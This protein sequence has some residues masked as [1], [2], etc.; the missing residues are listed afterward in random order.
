MIIRP[1]NMLY[2][3]PLFPIQNSVK[4]NIE[5]NNLQIAEKYQHSIWYLLLY[6][7]TA[8]FFFFSYTLLLLINNIY[9]GLQIGTENY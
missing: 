1:I 4:R 9:K 8:F 6:Q 3:L 5:K 7:R 2:N